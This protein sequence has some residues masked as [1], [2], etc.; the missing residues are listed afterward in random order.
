MAFIYR[1]FLT[2]SIAEWNNYSMLYQR[3]K[4]AWGTHMEGSV[5]VYNRQLEFWNENSGLTTNTNT[6]RFFNAIGIEYADLQKESY[7]GA[8]RVFLTFDWSKLNFTALSLETIVYKINTTIP[9]DTEFTLQV[10]YTGS[11]KKVAPNHLIFNN[12]LGDNDLTNIGNY[13]TDPNEI[14][15]MLESDPIAYFANGVDSAAGISVDTLTT[16]LIMDPLN[17]LSTTPTSIAPLTI[18]QAKG[19]NDIYSLA[20]L[21][22]NTDFVKVKVSNITYKITSNVPQTVDIQ[23]NVTYKRIHN[24]TT[25]STIVTRIKS[26]ADSIAS[27]Y[28]KKSFARPQLITLIEDTLLKTAI[29]SMDDTVYDTSVLLYNGYLRV[30]A[31]ANMKRKD[32]GKML[33]KVLKSDYDEVKAEWYEV[34]IAVILVV[35]AIVVGVISFGASVGGFSALASALAL[36]SAVLSIGLMVYANIFPYAMDMIRLIGKFAQM[37]GL[38]ASLLGILATVQSTFNK[39]AQAAGDRAAEEAAKTGTSKSVIEELKNKAIENYSIG[40]FIGDMFDQF[41]DSVTDKLSKM[42]DI[43]KIFDF[44]FGDLSDITLK[45][46]SG[47]LDNLKTGFDLYMKFFANSVQTTEDFKDQA[48]K[49]DGIEPYYGSLA[50]LDEVDALSKMH[51]MIEDSHGGTKTERFLTT[52]Y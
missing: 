27:S 1:D 43:N 32:F 33:T 9:I 47:W 39:F 50:M 30:D 36:S 16:S 44:K 23:Y 18:V 45:D 52:I 7:E 17:K 19:L 42:L 51:I 15:A 31:A 2:P 22:N 26:I 10:R 13:V 34:L 6:K 4:K 48:T 21:D 49:E 11:F 29:K 3:F 14:I 5:K 37:I 35:V 8:S 24:V 41:F 12:T 46:V 28:T 40:D 25:T 20:L 38:A